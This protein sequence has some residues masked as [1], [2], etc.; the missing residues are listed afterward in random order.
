MKRTN[1]TDIFA[2]ASSHPNDFVS[3]LP[4]QGTDTLDFSALSIGV[5]LSLYTNGIQS[6]HTNRTLQLNHGATFENV[7]GGSGI[8]TLTGAANTDW[9]FRALDDVISDLF[10]GE[11]EDLL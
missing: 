2:T 5:T 4:N 8:D 9:F 1:R 10:G 11:I 3:E 6:A 7:I